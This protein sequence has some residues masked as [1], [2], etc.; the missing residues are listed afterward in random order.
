MQS[1]F[2]NK[3]TVFLQT[4]NK[5]LNNSMKKKKSNRTFLVVQVYKNL[6]A[7]AG[8]MDSIPGSGRLHITSSN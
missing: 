8:H 7:K 3:S 1:E 4:S 5:Q 6:P 2:I